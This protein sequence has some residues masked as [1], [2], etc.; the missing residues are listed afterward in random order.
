MKKR[1]IW[2]HA[3]FLTLILLPVGAVIMRY[4]FGYWEAVGSGDPTDVSWYHFAFAI[5][6]CLFCPILFFEIELYRVVRY[7]TLNQYHTPLATVINL[8]SVSLLFLLCPLA[9]IPPIVD[10]IPPLFRLDVPV[11]ICLGHFVAI[12]IL[13]WLCSAI[14]KGSA[15]EKA[16]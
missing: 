2:V 4:F 9:I 14:G 5:N 13:V 12:R 10:R 8:V 3:V 16:H 11:F 15:D 1:H 7:F 6:L